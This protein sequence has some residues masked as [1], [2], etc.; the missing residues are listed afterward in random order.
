[1][2]LPMEIQFRDFCLAASGTATWGVNCDHDLL[3]FSTVL[4]SS[5]VQSTENIELDVVQANGKAAS[6]RAK[7]FFKRVRMEDVGAIS[8]ACPV[9]AVRLI[10]I[11]HPHGGRVVRLLA[12]RRDR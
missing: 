2:S 4:I 9:Q 3:P 10:V 5:P 1:M 8:F 12:G 7:A 11:V 6:L